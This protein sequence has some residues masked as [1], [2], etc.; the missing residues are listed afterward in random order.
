MWCKAEGKL[1]LSKL[2]ESGNPF[3]EFLEGKRQ[4]HNLKN[5]WKAFE[6][7]H[8]AAEHGHTVSK[9][10]LAEL[11]RKS[12]TGKER[13]V[14]KARDLYL[15]AAEEGHCTAQTSLGIM[16]MQAPCSGIE[17]DYKTAAMYFRKAAEQGDDHGQFCLAWMYQTGS[18]VPKDFLAAAF[19]YGRAADQG[20]MAAMERI[21][22]RVKTKY[23]AEI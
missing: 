14:L 19:W 22:R 15:E 13:N 20:H 1:G 16:Y 11:Y 23:V 7:Y 5:K 4:E 21:G 12:S 6:W 10:A 18:G 8:R 17:M 9:W 3:A 2:A